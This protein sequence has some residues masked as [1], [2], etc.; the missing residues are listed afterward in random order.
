MRIAFSSETLPH[1]VQRRAQQFRPWLFV[2]LAAAAYYPRF[3]KIPAGMETYP[4]AASCLWHGQMLQVCDQ[5]FT[6]PPFFALLMLPFVP[7]PLWLR[8]L[9]WYGVTLAAVIGAFK[10]SETIAARS[11]AAPLLRPELSWLRFFVLLL[12]AK[13]ILAV[14]ENQAYDALVLVAVVFGLW[15]LGA[16]RPLAAGAGLALA[17]ALKATPL[18]FLPYLLWKRYYAAAAA[19]ICVYAI[20]SLLPDV[21][22]T[23]AGSQ[24]F[25]V[26]GYFSTWLGEVAGPSLGVNPAGAPFVFWD[27][28]NILNHS[29]RGAVGL[30]IDEAH[31]GSLFEAALAATD[32]CFMVVVGTFIALSPRR[33]QSIALDG[34]LLLI[35]MLMLSPMTSRSHYVELLLPY[36]TLVALNLRDQRTAR[37]GRAVLLASFALVTLAGNDA[38]GEAFTIWAYR[39]SAM[40]LGALVLLIYFAALV[41]EQFRREQAAHYALAFP[42]R[43]A[44]TLVVQR[45][46]GIVQ[47][48]RI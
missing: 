26:A 45:G 9:V 44:G 32:G 4:Q 30:N 21:L 6:Y 7:M 24:G 27:G 39:H 28:A 29:L 47:A 40:V 48:R 3:V 34:S 17:A 10:L 2:G 22:L 1:K 8:D 19:F 5:G 41:M 46:S 20:A 23:Q 12:L 18:I 14:F 43:G 15:A 13:L 35:A 33:P 42:G 38:V 16:D 31:H 11:L 36:M 37:L 25:L